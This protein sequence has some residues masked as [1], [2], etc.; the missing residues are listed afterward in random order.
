MSDIVLIEGYVEENIMANVYL[1]GEHV[2]LGT[3]DLW[4][5][6]CFLFLRDLTA[7]KLG[8]CENPDC[9]APYYKKKRSTQK[10]CEAGPCVA[11]AQRQYA[12]R[13]WNA[14]GTRCERT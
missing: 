9:P 1:S 2:W 13:W 14:D 7:G 12:L 8:I 3:K 11:F 4:T 10:F 5:M 6:I